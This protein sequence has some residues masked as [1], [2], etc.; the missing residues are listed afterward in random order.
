MKR[1]LSTLLIF[2]YFNY[3]S[4][5]Q[6]LPTISQ[7]GIVSIS[8]YLKEQTTSKQIPGVVAIV[9]NKKEIIYKNVFGMNS[10][11]GSR[12]LKIDDIFAIASMTKAVTA[13]AV[14]QLY[15]QG[16]ITLNDPI[17]KYLLQINKLQVIDNFHERDT[18]FSTVS[19]KR[20][21]TIHDLLTHTSGI[22]YPLM[23]AAA[24]IAFV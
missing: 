18:S 10:I 20:P 17:T 3:Y 2:S 7:N 15:E 19:L 24:Y 4:V 12:A 11:K 6:S 5:S 22:G 21:V 13:V 8:T 14:M 1:F 23:K 9:A 16:K